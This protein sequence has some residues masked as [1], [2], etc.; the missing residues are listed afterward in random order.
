[1]SDLLSEQD[2]AHAMPYLKAA[3]RGESSR[4]EIRPRPRDGRVEDRT[5]QVHYVP[6]LAHGVVKGFIVLVFD[7][8]DVKRAE[9]YAESANLA[10]SAFLATMSHEI[11]TPL[12]AILGLAQAARLEH[13]PRDHSRSF[14]LIIQS[15]QHLLEIINDVLDFSKIEAGKLELRLTP[16]DLGELVHKGVA[17]VA[18]V[19]Q[20]KGLSLHTELDPRLDA[21]YLTDPVRLS[22]ILINLL[23]NAVKFTQQGQVRVAV[24]AAGTGVLLVV[25]D[26]GIGMDEQTQRRLFAPFSQGDGGTTRRYG[27]SGLGLSICKRLIDLM[28]GSI[29]VTS[30]AAKGSSFEVWLPLHAVDERE[31]T[32]STLGALQAC[33]QPSERRRTLEGVR[34]LVAED[35]P[36]NQMVLQELLKSQGAI[37]RMVANGQELVDEV[38]AQGDQACQNYDLILCD[39]EMPIMDGYE[40][41]RIV[42]ELAPGLAVVGLTAHAFEDARER[43]GSSGMKAYVTKP[44]MLEDL[45]AEILRQL[46]R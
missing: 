41:T 30:A 12:N 22:Q 9:H 16:V 14:D 10:K 21:Y 34:I 32:P 39:I 11:R 18:N 45:V 13:A 43:G 19:A 38:R 40:A 4:F 28:E 23:S 1:M 24:Q 42:G 31:P 35:Q 5:F 27:G 20:S 2:Y 26:S 36:L 3:L 33:A 15:G 17:M 37:L 7:I 6:D 44:Y 25:Q 46:P 29:K 8:S